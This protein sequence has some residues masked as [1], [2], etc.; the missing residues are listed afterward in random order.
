MTNGDKIRGMD[1]DR[2]ARFLWV[3]TINNLA[4]FF[5]A[6][7]TETMNAKQLREWMDSTE[8]DHKQVHVGEDFIFDADFN[9]K[10]S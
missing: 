9:L 7:F 6:G 5:E 4:M 3:W 8:W 1:N 10:E 2:L